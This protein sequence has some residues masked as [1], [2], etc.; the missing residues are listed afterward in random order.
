MAM[1]KFKYLTGFVFLTFLS[2]FILSKIGQNLPET[3]L[4]IQKQTGITDRKDIQ[5]S[6][7][8]TG[9]FETLEGFLYAGGSFFKIKK[10][11]HNAT[12]ISHPK[13]NLLI[14]TGLGRKVD[15]QFLEIPTVFKPLFGYKKKLPAADVLAKHHMKVSNIVLTHMHWDHASGLKDF[16]NP[17]IYTTSSEYQFSE[18]VDAK[19]PAYV[20]SQYAG[21]S[22]IRFIEFT[23]GP[24]EIFDQSFDFYKDGS[25]VIVRLEGHSPGSLGIFVNL[26]KNQRYFFTGDLTWSMAGF[27]NRA[28][29]FYVSSLLVDTDRALIEK[30]IVGIANFLQLRP[31]IKVIPAH[32]HNAFEVLNQLKE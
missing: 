31:E 10:G 18:S 27:H 29:K 19:P 9:T 21:L 5:I 12:L 14:D 23:D 15:E 17:N 24:Y 28:H 32:D 13:G 7:I 3:K 6:T 26:S 22:N 4:N 30:E 8:Q 16:E 1:K 25:I 20:K 2:F 11:T